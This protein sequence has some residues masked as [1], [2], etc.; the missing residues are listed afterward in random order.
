MY[1][2]YEGTI[3]YRLG[4]WRNYAP[5]CDLAHEEGST[6]SQACRPAKAVERLLRA[7]NWLDGDTGWMAIIGWM[8]RRATTQGVG[9]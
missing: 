7:D 5:G 3:M 2:E 1:S 9:I 8:A 6:V 4:K